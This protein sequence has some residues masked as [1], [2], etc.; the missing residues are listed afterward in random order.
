[1]TEFMTLVKLLTL[2]SLPLALVGGAMWIFLK[3][4]NAR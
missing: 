2:L 4:R 3:D 1:M